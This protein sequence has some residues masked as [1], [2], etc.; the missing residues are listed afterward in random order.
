MNRLPIAVRIKI[1]QML[2]ERSSMRSIGR[3]LDVSPNTVDKLLREA[4]E[5]CLAIHDQE[6]RNVHAQRIQCD[7][8]W[9]FC[10]AKQK[11]VAT[12]I[13]APKEAGD[14]WTWT[15]IDP[16]TKLVV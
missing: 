11:N 10:Y 4:G 8:I 7:E 6:V 12:A 16:Q 15:A 3:V 13:N 5:A 14:V 9:S 1:L 2:I